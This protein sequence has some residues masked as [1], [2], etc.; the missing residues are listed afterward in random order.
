[1]GISELI[2][3]AELIVVVCMLL[4]GIVGQENIVSLLLAVNYILIAALL[5]LLFVEK[6]TYQITTF[7]A[8][9]IIIIL[10]FSSMAIYGSLSFA[11]ARKWLMF[12]CVMSLYFWAY[13][14]RITKRMIIAVLIFGLA[15]AGIFMIS[16]ISGYTYPLGDVGITFNLGNPNFTGMW[17]L[18]VFLLL[19]VDIEYFKNRVIR[20]LLVLFA[21]V[22][23]YFLTLTNARGAILSAV[24]IIP[25]RVFYRKKYS[26]VITF[27]A[28]IF[29][30][31]F[32]LTY[33]MFINNQK[34]IEFFSFLIS[35][36]KNL[37]S[38]IVIW[39]VGFDLFAEYPI[40]GNYYESTGGSGISQYHNIYVDTL[41]TYGAI[42]Q[43]A[44]IAF[45]TWILNGIGKG[46]KNGG[47]ALA[48]ISAFYVAIISGCF[49]GGLFSNSLGVYVLTGVLLL[50]ARYDQNRQV[51]QEISVQ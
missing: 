37:T 25:F 22:I 18:A 16:Y 40:F 26:P 9:A 20:I 3:F 39:E 4:F 29:P 13:N 49:E 43:A 41:C 21:F 51:E 6:R 1:M 45:L 8:F 30:L 14:T 5:I 50:L 11:Y 35:E 15:Q 28:V 38:R 24:C 33:M 32:A 42:V 27:C 44:V 19:V 36:G 34:V 17:L 10:S 23:F 31:V 12:F 47:V 48:A 2:F 7:F 46:I